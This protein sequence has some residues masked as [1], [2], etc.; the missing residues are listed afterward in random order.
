[1]KAVYYE[2]IAYPPCPGQGVMLVPINHPNCKNNNVWVTTTP[3]VRI[4][5]YVDGHRVY[6]VFETQNTIYMPIEDQGSDECL[7]TDN[8][9]SLG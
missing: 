1:M 6:G 4:V 2:R 8:P 7:N 9:G 5:D 3:V